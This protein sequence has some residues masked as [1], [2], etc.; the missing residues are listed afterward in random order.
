MVKEAEKKSSKKRRK[1]KKRKKVIRKNNLLMS[2]WLFKN[3]RYKY[4]ES[5]TSAT[6]NDG[7]DTRRT[8]KKRQRGTGKRSRVFSATWESFFWK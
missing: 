3:N 5:K 1:E 7:I 4:S 6:K 8:K 2:Y